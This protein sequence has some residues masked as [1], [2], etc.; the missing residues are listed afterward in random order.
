MKKLLTLLPIAIVSMGLFFTSCKKNSTTSADLTTEFKDQS[1]DQARF[2]NETDAVANDANAAMENLGGSY[3]GDTP[4]TPQLPAPCDATIAVDTASTP[5]KITITYLGTNC[6]G[7]RTRTG[8]VVISFAPTFRWVNAGAYFTV[9]YQNLRI[10]RVSDSKSI[11]INGEKRITNVSGGKLRNLATRTTPIVHEVTSSSMNI[12]FDDGTQRSWQ[13]AKRRTF[14]Y[15]DNGIVIS[16]T[17]FGPQGGGVAEWGINRHNNSF[18]SAIIEP[19]VVKQSCNF[20]LVSG[21]IKHTGP[22]VTVNTTFGLDATG[23]PVTAC[24]TGAF[25]YKLVWTGANGLS[26]T[27]IAPY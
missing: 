23:N 2:S 11:L 14:T 10:T 19:M 24:P 3:A 7:N 16:V 9:N 17:G 22:V 21:K 25:Y 13:I 1:D 12:T 20:R 27:H 4:L 18:T 6:L 8:T 26:Y 15:Y 5:R